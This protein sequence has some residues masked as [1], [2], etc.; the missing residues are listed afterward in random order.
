MEAKTLLLTFAPKIAAMSHFRAAPSNVWGRLS[1]KLGLVFKG[2]WTLWTLRVF[3][4]HVCR[5]TQ[6]ASQPR[7][8]R[9][10]WE[11]H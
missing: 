1:G 11:T 7:L 10:T 4:C 8:P 6:L 5:R 9:S 3:A 2:C